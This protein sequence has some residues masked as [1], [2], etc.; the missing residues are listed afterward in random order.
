MSIMTE[1]IGTSPSVMAADT[2]RGLERR[3]AHMIRWGL[4]RATARVEREWHDDASCIGGTTDATRQVASQA[5]PV[6]GLLT[7]ALV[8]GFLLTSL[9]AAQVS[10]QPPAASVYAVTPE[11]VAAIVAVVVAL[12]GAVAGGFALARPIGNSAGRR[13]ATVALVTG[14]TGLVIG[15]LVVATADGGLG[16]GNGLAGGVVAMIVGL[17]AMTLGGLALARSRRMA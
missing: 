3:G 11:R 10:D 4:R 13:G 9:A 12:I 5:S 2:K 14:S 8:A 6:T 7:A 16:T 15:W 1:L 17:I